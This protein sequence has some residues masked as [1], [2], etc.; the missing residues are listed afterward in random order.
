M[1]LVPFVEAIASHP[2]ARVQG[3]AIFLTPNLQGVPH[4]LLHNLK[5]NK[6]LHEKVVLLA[7]RIENVPH[8]AIEE[9]IKVEDLGHHFYR[10]TMYYGFKDDEN[11]P[12]DLQQ[13]KPFGLELEEMDTSYFVGKESLIPSESSEM[14]FWKL[15]LFI[16]MFRNADS[17]IH[18]FK[19]PANRVVELG[20]Q[21]TL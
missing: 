17:V 20:A 10:V 8:I 1:D 21:V 6:V 14:P 4:A 7:V 15:K 19:L 18:Q 2:P 9:R 12:Q 16:G 11:I 5:H 13:C 3:N